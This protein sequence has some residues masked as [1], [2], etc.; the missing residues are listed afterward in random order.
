AEHDREPRIEEVATARLLERFAQ[1]EP[2][3]RGQGDAQTRGGR[4]RGYALAGPAS[5][6]QPVPRD[7]AAWAFVERLR[8]GAEDQPERR[9]GREVDARLPRCAKV[10]A[11]AFD[12]E[13]V[14][15]GDRRRQRAR[16]RD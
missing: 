8:Q 11:R 12:H 9:A 14:G 6:D 1:T 10:T 15:S 16:L 3:K 5:L 7:R 13:V 2:P 4:V